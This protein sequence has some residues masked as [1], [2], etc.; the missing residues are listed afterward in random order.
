M[1]RYRY[2]PDVHEA[3]QW[4]CRSDAETW[5]EGVRW[6]K[7]FGYYVKTIGGAMVSLAEGDWIV[8]EDDGVHYRLFSPALFAMKF[9]EVG[10]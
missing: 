6:D 2:E 4:S 3:F 8:T 9:T 5:P 1:P 7:V 10:G